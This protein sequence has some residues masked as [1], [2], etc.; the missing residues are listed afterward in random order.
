MP[1]AKRRTVGTRGRSGGFKRKPYTARRNAKM[2]VKF[3]KAITTV[4]NRQIHAKLENKYAALTIAPTQIPAVIGDFQINN[5]L[6][7]MPSI[8]RGT[9]PSQRI[10]M[11]ISP[12]YMEIRGWLTL[13]MNDTLQDYDRVCVRLILGRPKKYP[14]Y[15]QAAS[16]VTGSPYTNWSSELINYGAG[17][18]RFA[19]TLEALQ[20]P[21]NSGVFTTMAERRMTI[22]RPRF[23]DAPLVGSDSFRYSGNSTRFFRIR[24]KCPKTFIYRTPE[25]NDPFPNNF[26][27][28]LLAGYSLL[29][30]ST[31]AEPDVSPRPVTISYTTRLT[32]EDA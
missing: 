23:Y 16:E 22:T 20:S 27:P 31:P 18:A 19:G 21:V 24:V 1:Y 25:G 15:P 9:L 28:V 29:N 5:V 6:N 2:P 13:D 26:N 17:A 14:L 32:Y 12:R 7:I 4:V 10:G 3:R 8:Q 11:K 30:G